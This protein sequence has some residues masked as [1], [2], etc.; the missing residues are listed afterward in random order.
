MC[1]NNDSDGSGLKNGTLQNGNGTAMSKRKRVPAFSN[2]SGFGTTRKLFECL[3]GLSIPI[4]STIVHQANEPSC[5]VSGLI[6]FTMT[7]YGIAYTF[8]RHFDQ[9]LQPPLSSW[10][11][12]STD[13]TKKRR[14][15]LDAAAEWRSRL[16]AIVNALVLIV[17]SG[18]CFTE[19]VS[20]YV[21][22]SE[23]WVKT[24]P[25]ECD[26]SDSNTECSCFVSYPVVFASLFVGYLQWDLCWYIWHRDTHPD[27]GGMIHH[28]IFIAVTQFVL[29][30][31]Y[32]RKSFAWL[33]FT[34]LSTPFLHIRWLL[35][36]TGNKTGA[37]YSWVCIGFALTFL[38]TRTIGYGL[39]LIDVWLNQESWGSVSGLWWVVSGLHLGYILNLFWSLKVGS[40]LLR[41]IIGG[42]KEKSSKKQN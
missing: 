13:E 24:L 32:F 39:G 9:I 33:S 11:V 12:T 38:S 25:F 14:Q 1:V 16:L 4:W 22:A 2:R 18:L 42:N 19:W 23:G 41:I 21:P 37:L 15:Q 40:A 30:E 31:T 28:S 7:M 3:L 26:N 8:L 36:A 29:S 17:G 5:R 27:V 35:A 6:A 20:T 34:E 10:L